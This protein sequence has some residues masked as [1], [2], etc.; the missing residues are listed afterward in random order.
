M[1]VQPADT[2]AF[3]R[4]YDFNNTEVINDGI[5]VDDIEVIRTSGDHGRGE[6][7]TL[8]GAVSGFILKSEGNPTVYIVGDCI[9]R[10]EIQAT[11]DKYDPDWVI[12][13]SG[14]A[15]VPD[16]SPELGPILMN[17]NDVVSLIKSAPAKCRFI[18]VHMEAIDHCQTTRSILRNEAERADISKDKLII[19]ADGETV[20]L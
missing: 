18:A 7:D 15:I 3:L 2:V 8:M 6:L 14:G 11:I 19:P 1:Y 13:N 4:E 9:Y 5:I 10:P 20:L 12:L 17:E 16:L